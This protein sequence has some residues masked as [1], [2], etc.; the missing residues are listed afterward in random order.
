MKTLYFDTGEGKIAYDDEGSGPLVACVPGMGD[1]RGEYRFLKAQLLDA[2]YRVV[3]MDVRGHGESSAAGWTGFT[4]AEVGGDIV[5]LMRSL[6]AGPGVVIGTSMAAG[7]AVWAA[8]EA[9]E[10][11]NGLALIGPAV[12]GEA[13]GPIRL[14]Y[15]LLFT[16]PWGPA[17]WLMYF[18]TLYPTRKPEDFEA[19]CVR[20]K[21][22]LKQRGR[23]EALHQMAL[24]SKAASEERLTRVS[25][26]TLVMM[27][28]KDPDFK[29][30][31]AEAQWVAERVNGEVVIIPGAGHYPHAEMPEVAGPHI[32]R[33]LD[34]VNGC[35]ETEAGA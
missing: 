27:G 35:V 18:K 32:L 24:A 7:A 10:L 30:P 26:P 33:F 20:L 5:G 14:V 19:Y 29:D 16:R 4:V 15:N 28:S 25:A 34:R 6:E 13:S 23:L 8:A 22:N 11:V 1:L 31:Q 9:P 17:A 12:H 21:E 3:T 2:G